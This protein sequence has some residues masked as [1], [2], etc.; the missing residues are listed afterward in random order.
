MGKLP[1]Q[2]LRRKQGDSI[3]ISSNK[4]EKARRIPGTHFV[5]KNSGE[6]EAEGDRRIPAENDNW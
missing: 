5:Y 2:L 1:G 4:A 3:V 6:S